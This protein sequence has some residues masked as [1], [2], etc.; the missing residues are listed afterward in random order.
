MGMDFWP[1]SRPN[2]PKNT[3]KTLTAVWLLIL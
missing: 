1:H 3:H 2:N